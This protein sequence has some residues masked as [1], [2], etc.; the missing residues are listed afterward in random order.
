MSGHWGYSNPSGVG[1]PHIFAAFCDGH[2]GTQ[3][4][5]PREHSSY[6]LTFN[7]IL[8]FAKFDPFDT[9]VETE[10][11]CIAFSF[12]GGMI[13]DHNGVVNFGNDPNTLMVAYESDTGAGALSVPLN[14]STTPGSGFE[15]FFSPYIT[16]GPPG[17]INSSP[18]PSPISL[19]DGFCMV[20]INNDANYRGGNIVVRVEAVETCLQLFRAAT[21]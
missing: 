5:K 14:G 3:R 13:V 1:I 12:K 8:N 7:C 4:F 10:S 20:V 17:P 15:I 2:G 19:A 11:H 9:A 21:L 18:A 16:T 6:A